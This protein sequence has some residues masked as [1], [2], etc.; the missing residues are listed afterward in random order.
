MSNACSDQ[1]LVNIVMATVRLILFLNQKNDF[2]F[3]FTYRTFISLKC[4]MNFDIGCFFPN[5]MSL[6]NFLM[7]QV[8]IEHHGRHCVNMG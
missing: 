2:R 1:M 6:S 5:M 4:G 7:Q 8:F 3:M